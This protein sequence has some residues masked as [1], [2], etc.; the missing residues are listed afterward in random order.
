MTSPE[1][2]AMR[3][4][5]TRIAA[6]VA[7]MVFVAALA[8]CSA[9]A[10]LGA[11]EYPDSAESVTERYFE[12]LGEGD[13]ATARALEWKHQVP[14]TGYDESELR[15]LTDLSIGDAS[16]ESPGS[17]A[18]LQRFSEIAIV[19]VGFTR[20]RRSSI[21]EPPGKDARFV[22]LGLEPGSNRWRVISYGTGP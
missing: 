3:N 16:T 4:R 18:E 14:G 6:V 17:H 1:R 2:G 12:A 20:V 22:Q 13:E 10:G 8:G 5:V 15:G 9:R 11:R 19:P 7:C 21:G